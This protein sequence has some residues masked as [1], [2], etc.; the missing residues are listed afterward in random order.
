MVFQQVRKGGRE[1]LYSFSFATGPGDPTGNWRA[2][3]LIGDSTFDH[4]LKIE[5][6]VPFRLKTEIDPA[7][8][9]L[10]REDEILAVELRS[11]YL[12][13]SPAAGLDAELAVSLQSAEKTFAGFAGFSFTNELIDYQPV[14]AVIFKGRLDA[15]GR[16]AVEWTLPDMAGVPSVLQALLTAKVLEKGGRPNHRRLRLPIDPYD[17]EEG[18]EPFPGRGIR[19]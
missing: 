3:V 8:E 7:R 5:T 18:G 2:R 1:G 4:V 16:T 11:A 9:R 6:V 14:K 10:G 13:G 17:P 15:K 19:S 12:F